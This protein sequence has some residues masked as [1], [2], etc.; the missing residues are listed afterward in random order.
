MNWLKYGLVSAFLDSLLNMQIVLIR[1]SE[2]EHLLLDVLAV[3]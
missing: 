1:S 3:R 2:R